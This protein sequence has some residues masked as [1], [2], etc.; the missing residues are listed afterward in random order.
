MALPTVSLTFTEVPTFNKFDSQFRIKWSELKGKP[1]ED[2]YRMWGDEALLPLWTQIAS[3]AIDRGDALPDT[4]LR[5][6]ELM[7]LE[8]LVFGGVIT[9]SEDFELYPQPVAELV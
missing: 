3:I 4:T 2:S 5:C 8:D 7:E 6:I 1:T 9:L